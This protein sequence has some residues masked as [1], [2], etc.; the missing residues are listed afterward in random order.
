MSH[1]RLLPSATTDALYTGVADPYGQFSRA[2]WPGKLHSEFEFAPRRAAESLALA[3][4]PHLPGRDDYGGW[5]DGPTLPATGFF[6]T[7]KRDGRWWLVTP[8]GHLFLSFG[9]DCVNRWAA[10]IVEPRAALFTG[11]PAPTDPLAK[12]YGQED[13]VLYGP[14][15]SGRTFNFYE[16]NLQ[17]KYGPDFEQVW[18][19]TSLA[20]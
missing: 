16:A 13:H 10:T 8:K 15:K 5:A 19:D 1:L 6:T 20:R 3:A 2:D 12:F 18:G 11:L 14:Y 7:T 9:M 4:A 17:R